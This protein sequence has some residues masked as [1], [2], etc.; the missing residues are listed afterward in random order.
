M[1]RVVPKL[2]G[3]LILFVSGTQGLK[4]KTVND[5]I[6]LGHDEKLFTLDDRRDDLLQGRTDLRQHEIF[7][8]VSPKV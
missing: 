1:V 2:V 4:R 5:S 8:S 6:H 7:R 3:I